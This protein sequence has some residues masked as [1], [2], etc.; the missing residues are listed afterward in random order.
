MFCQQERQNMLIRN[1]RR[2]GQTKYTSIYNS[3][4]YFQKLT[5]T[6]V[7]IFHSRDCWNDCTWKQKHLTEQSAWLYIKQYYVP[8][9]NSDGKSGPKSHWRMHFFFFW[10]G[11]LATLSVVCLAMTKKVYRLGLCMPDST[12]SY[13]SPSWLTNLSREQFQFILSSSVCCASN[14]SIFNFLSSFLS[15]FIPLI[16]IGFT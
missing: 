3:Q 7:G 16:E 8:L 14:R 10:M 12:V 11:E 15:S 5:H 2:I 6:S 9:E 13:L 4:T 1:Q